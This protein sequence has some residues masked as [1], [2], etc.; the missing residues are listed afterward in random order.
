MEIRLPRL[1]VP[2]VN[3]WPNS[4]ITRVRNADKRF[5]KITRI[6]KTRERP[7]FLPLDLVTV[8][9]LHQRGPKNGN[10]ESLLSLLE[11]RFG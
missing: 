11:R 3:L 10:L 6:F 1:V 2:V 9:Q 4:E 8:T 5:W 7:Q